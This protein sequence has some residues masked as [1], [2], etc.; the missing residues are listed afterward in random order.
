M[1]SENTWL[2]E[3]IDEA[4]VMVNHSG[5]VAFRNTLAHE[6]FQKLGYIEDILGQRYENIRPVE[7]EQYRG[8]SRYAFVESTVGNL[9]LAIKHVRLNT[10]DIAFVVV[11]QDI[12]WNK[13][14]EK[15]LI[16]KS[17][18]IKEMHHRVKNNLQTI[19]SLLRLQVRRTEN[20][21]TR[22]VLSESM[23]RILSIAATHELLA[24]SGVDQVMIGEVLMH[25]EK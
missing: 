22:A 19:A 2:T 18:A 15:E 9:T 10:Q 16:L 17:V 8:D 7:P 21:E 4:L 13:Q 23:N 1:A 11:I 24:Q 6:L 25:I 5:I 20:D 3:C 14:Q 12:T